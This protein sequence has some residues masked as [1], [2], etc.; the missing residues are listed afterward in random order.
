MESK[1]FIRFFVLILLLYPFLEI[2]GQIP[3]VVSI[4][5]SFN[6][7]SSES[8]PEI[9]VQFN[10][11]MEPVSFD[12]ISF[13]VFGE[14]SAYHTGE[15]KFL[16]ENK[17]VSFTSNYNFNAGE[18]VTINLSKK[19]ISADGDTL[20]GFSWT[21]RIPSQAKSLNF[22]EPVTY[23]GGGYGMQCVDMN[24]DR[25]ADIVTSSGV[26]LINNGNG[27]FL[28]SWYL[29]DADDFYPII[30]DDFN[31]DNFI[32]VF[33]YG[34]YGLTLGLGNG[35]GSFTKSYYPPQWFGDY[36]STDVNADGFPDIIGINML[37]K[38]PDYDTTSYFAIAL[39]DGTGHL[40]DTIWGGYLTGRFQKIAHS[41]VDND[42]D[43]DI[44]IISQLAVIPGPIITGLDGLAIFKNNGAGIFNN[45]QLIPACND[46][47][48]YF[49]KYLYSS[50]FNR[51]GFID[52]AVLADM[53]GGV[54]L[55]KG[56]GIFGECFDTLNTWHFWG[57]ELPAAMTG[58]D[59]NG[60]SW[61]DT[62]Q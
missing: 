62:W 29:N 40:N 7:I 17:T 18:R 39:N 4:S 15:L 60:D 31:R 47:R 26:I 53:G 57:A 2:N 44:L 61:I 54:T 35:M 46:F 16:N 42:G 23:S 48:I 51:D 37:F 58:G 52:I 8:N 22:S 9:F 20:N 55:N 34:V 6:E 24:N 45:F 43:S 59:L 38:N 25:Y 12:N 11:A 28:S 30:T 49:P 3:E 21:F 50:D 19:I 1:F 10:V 5:P 56:N 36:I 13:S 27:E 14:R 41:D 32:D 33:Y